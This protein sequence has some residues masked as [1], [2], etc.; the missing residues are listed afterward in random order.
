M[1]IAVEQADF[2]G[3][4][5][6]GMAIAVQSPHNGPGHVDI[7]IAALYEDDGT[8]DVPVGNAV[9]NEQAQPGPRAKNSEDNRGPSMYSGTLIPVHLGCVRD[10]WCL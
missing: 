1:R 10:V 6:A 8:V 3:S 9:V 2:I 7:G 4:H 5:G